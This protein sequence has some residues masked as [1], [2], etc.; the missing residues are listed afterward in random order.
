MVPFNYII[1]RL[2][3]AGKNKHTQIPNALL[4]FYFLAAVKLFNQFSCRTSDQRWRSQRPK[5]T[6]LRLR[7]VSFVQRESSSSLLWWPYKYFTPTNS[8]PKY[9]PIHN[10][11]LASTF[12]SL[13]LL[14]GRPRS[15]ALSSLREPSPRHES[16]FRRYSSDLMATRTIL[17]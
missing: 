6:P 5:R 3:G 12:P 9:S 14:S 10:L 11:P 15:K 13:H 8:Y 2:N 1:S 4:L 16:Q 17:G 7:F